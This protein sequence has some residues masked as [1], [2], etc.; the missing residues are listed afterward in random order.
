M[1]VQVIDTLKLIDPS[2]DFERM[3]DFPPVTDHVARVLLGF[4]STHWD[5]ERSD[6]RYIDLGKK[7]KFF[8]ESM[9]IRISYQTKEKEYPLWAKTAAAVSIV[10]F[11]AFVY[12]APL[13][14]NAR[15]I[16]GLCLAVVL[17]LP[18]P[19]RLDNVQPRYEALAKD[20]KKDDARWRGLVQDKAEFA[21]FAKTYAY[22]QQPYTELEKMGIDIQARLKG[23]T[24]QQAE[25][26]LEKA[27]SEGAQ[28]TLKFIEKLEAIYQ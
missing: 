7:L 9:A 6:P 13:S 1:S 15:L 22:A 2:T 8:E 19:K 20:L 23:I 12:L 11:A 27:K 18:E 17:G 28:E 24:T 5:M 10:A 4:K 3:K 25:A 21:E 26:N 14:F 16:S